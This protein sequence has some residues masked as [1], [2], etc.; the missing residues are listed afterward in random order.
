M[1][2]RKY[3]SFERRRQ[4]QSRPAVDMEFHVWDAVRQRP[5]TEKVQGRLTDISL[6]GACLQTNQTLIQGHHILLDDDPEG[7]TP[8]ALALPSP[9]EENGRT[10][11][12][13]V[14]WYNRI[15]AARRYQ[16]DVGL[17]FVDLS[18]IERQHLESLLKALSTLS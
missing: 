9:G 16:F 12:A 2:I 7:N 15:A 8:L 13:Q 11:K 3:F 1:G 4:W 5:L 17:K 10:I 18:P 14:V 6:E